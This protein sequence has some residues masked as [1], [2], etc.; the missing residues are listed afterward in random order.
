MKRRTRFAVAVAVI[1]AACTSPEVSEPTTTTAASSTSP[2]SSA[3]TTITAAVTTT[4]TRAGVGR[5][6]VSEAG[7]SAAELADF[8]EEFR[9]VVVLEHSGDAADV[10]EFLIDAAIACD[11]E[12]LAAL[13]ETNLPENEWGWGTF[14]GATQL[15][16]VALRHSDATQNALWDLAVA[17]IYTEPAW[18]FSEC[19]D[20]G[21]A[22]HCDLSWYEWPAWVTSDMSSYQLERMALLDGTTAEVLADRLRDG[23]STFGVVISW[24][25]RWMAAFA[26][27]PGECVAVPGSATDR[28][29]E[30]DWRS[31]F[32][33]W[34][35]TLGCPVR[36]DVVFEALGDA[37]CDFDDA[38]Y[39]LTGD[40]LGA[41]FSTTAPPI[42]YVRDPTGAYVSD[43]LPDGFAEFPELPGD[44]VDSGFR[45]RDRELWTS[46]SDPAA[47]FI[48]D[49]QG[50]ER[51]PRGNLPP[52]F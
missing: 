9:D 2:P 11:F 35:D 29:D 13:A 1:V 33:P 47:I 6:P 17:L 14:W 44:A 10:R 49:S 52:C 51:W 3:V 45:L 18:D 50:V 48:K 15:D 32:L 27:A 43:F 20:G 21:N 25:G 46:P 38:R 36:V 7:C 30:P 28:S 5:P 37:H 26:P 19:E 34:T 8:R 31:S 16:A 12:T 40:P 39:L 23:Y 41:R 4:T 42:E 22:W 24:D